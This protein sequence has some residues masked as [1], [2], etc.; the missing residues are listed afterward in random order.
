MASYPASTTRPHPRASNTNSGAFWMVATMLLGLAVAVVGFFALMM[1]ADSRESRDAAPQ[2]AA[3]DGAPTSAAQPQ[4]ADH[5]TALPLNS[6]A[7]VVP[8]NA[9]ELADAHK[10]Y[11]RRSRLCP[12]ATWSRCR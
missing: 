9:A 1:W 3:S 5:N 11:E 8:E 4:V 10:A 12:Q 2:P 6:F 7:G